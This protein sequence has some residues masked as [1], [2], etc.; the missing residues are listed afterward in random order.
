[1][2]L[3]SEIGTQT[4]VTS[5]QKENG[6]QTSLISPTNESLKQKIRE[7]QKKVNLK[8]ACITNLTVQ[9][10]QS[11]QTNFNATALEDKLSGFALEL[12]KN[13]VENQKVPKIAR[14]YSEEVEQFAVNLYSYSPKAYLFVSK[15]LCLPSCS[16]IKQLLSKTYY[17]VEDND[18][19]RIEIVIDDDKNVANNDQTA[20]IMISGNEIK[21]INQN[22]KS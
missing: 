6:T 4:S 13:Q 20:I 19:E 17:V 8:T 7:L 12:F 22:S 15:Q 3:T 2:P 18:E 21:L 14:K 16:K 5:L 10:Q 1:M 9:L 11:K